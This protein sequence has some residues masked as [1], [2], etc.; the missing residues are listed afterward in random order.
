MRESDL[1]TGGANLTQPM[2]IAIRQE[3][4]PTFLD[5]AI[6]QGSARYLRS[7]RRLL[8]RV[9]RNELA[10]R[11]AGSHLG[12][13]WVLLAPGFVLVV[14]AVTYVAIFKI[15]L[16]GLTSTEYVIFI[17]SG[18]VPY[19]MAADALANGVGSVLAN[20]Y[21]LSN[22]VFPIDLAPVKA[23]LSSQMIMAVGMAVTVVGSALVGT[24]RWTV[25]LLPVIWAMQAVGLM[26][27]VWFIS[28]LNVI[29]RDIQNFLTPILMM[30]LIISPIAYT[31]EIVPQSL[32]PL[33]L[34]NPFAYF[35]VAYQQI[36]VLGLL[37]SPAHAVVMIVLAVVPFVLGSWFFATAKR[38]IIDYV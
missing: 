3:K 2:R 15:R 23:V 37:P 26:G 7:H 12:L 6:R 35:V 31:P 29:F 10:A 34:L 24:L 36:L 4:R 14:Y 25:V 11:Y 17:F 9:T 5:R 18:L 21:V 8:L 32:K 13:F 30:M 33:I 22:T 16:A 19:L 20:K 28:L 38:V 27:I 1:A